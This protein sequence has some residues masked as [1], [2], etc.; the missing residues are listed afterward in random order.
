MLRSDGLWQRYKRQN[1]LQAREQLIM[2]HAYLAKYVVDRMPI[3]P[4]AVVGYDDLLGHAIVGLID[5][6]ER[7]DL[8]HG[9]KFE[10]Y[11]VTR[12]RGSVL[13]ALKQLDWIPRSVRASERNLRE[14][15]AVLEG[16]LGRPA[17][18][19]EIAREMGISL[20]ELD[21]LLA[22][23]GQSSILSLEQALMD[24]EECAADEGFMFS[25]EHDP[26]RNAEVEARKA[27][28]AGAIGALPD[29]ERLVI[30]LYYSEGLTFKEIAKVLGV[31]E[32]RICQLHSKAVSRLNG[33]LAGHRELLLAAA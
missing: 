17:E 28:L 22:D 30:S 7:F 21:K 31:T 26:A 29:K 12:I 25:D 11:A 18:D 1:D 10:T 20:D 32:S 13:D 9:V 5:A 33:K 19:E 8:S 24:G 15:M 14:V 2:A 4:S 23:T 6:V 3:R 16:R 27:M